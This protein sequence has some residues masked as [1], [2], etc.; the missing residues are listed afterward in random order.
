MKNAK[1]IRSALRE[2]EAE[3]LSERKRADDFEN[4][5]E[6]LQDV[7]RQV[8]YLVSHHLFMLMHEIKDLGWNE[9]RAQIYDLIKARREPFNLILASKPDYNVPAPRDEK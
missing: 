7:E 1:I 3:L 6:C 9:D 4:S 5:L 2:M 8:A